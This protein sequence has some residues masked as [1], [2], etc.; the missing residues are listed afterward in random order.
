MEW[1]ILQGTAEEVQKTL[2]QWRHIYFIT[3]YGYTT[4]GN[5]NA[6]SVLLTRERKQNA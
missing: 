3:I 6:V 5:I 2:N 1:K 4:I